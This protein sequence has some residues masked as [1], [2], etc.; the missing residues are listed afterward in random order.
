MTRVIPSESRYWQANCTKPAPSPVSPNATQPLTTGIGSNRTGTEGARV[1]R[2]P[3]RRLKSTAPNATNRHPS[4]RP[5]E[6]L[7]SSGGDAALGRIDLN[8]ILA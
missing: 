6:S 1:K 3:V 2:R 7:C 8:F 5:H 4:Q